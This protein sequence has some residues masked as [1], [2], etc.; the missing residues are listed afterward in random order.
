MVNLLQSVNIEGDTVWQASANDPSEASWTPSPRASR[1]FVRFCRGLVDN[2]R[3]ILEVAFLA[4]AFFLAQ[5]FRDFHVPQPVAE[6][7]ST[8]VIHEP[9]VTEP[10]PETPVV[11]DRVKHFLNCTFEDYRTQHYAE[12]VDADSDIYNDPIADPDDTGHIF[13]EPPLLLAA[14]IPERHE[15]HGAP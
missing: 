3:L 8:P 12:C 4:G 7:D 5:D 9:F 15:Q 11:T 6:V 14:I 13:R 10:V 1:C 2:L